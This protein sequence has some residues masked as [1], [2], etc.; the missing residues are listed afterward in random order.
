MPL[1]E[2]ILSNAERAGVAISAERA[3]QIA[4]AAQPRFEAFAAARARLGFD[5]APSFESALLATR[6]SSEPAP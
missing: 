2:T 6:A 4:S 5:D 1:T 3:V